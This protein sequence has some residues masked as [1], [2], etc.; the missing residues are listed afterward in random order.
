MKN[1]VLELLKRRDDNYLELFCEKGV[2]M[3]VSGNLVGG[4]CKPASIEKVLEY[5]HQYDARLLEI[6]DKHNRE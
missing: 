1:E 4:V 3:D 2:Y 6:F 5:I